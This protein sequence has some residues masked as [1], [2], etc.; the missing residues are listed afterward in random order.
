MQ[1]AMDRVDKTHREILAVQQ[2]AIDEL[3][4]RLNPPPAA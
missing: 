3:Y 2:Q 1:R 4:R